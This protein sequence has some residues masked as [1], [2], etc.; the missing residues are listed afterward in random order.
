MIMQE[1]AKT[2]IDRCNLAEKLNIIDDAQELYNIRKLR[3][4]IAHEY[5]ISD[6]SKI[7]KDVLEYTEVLLKTAKK[8]QSYIDK[9]L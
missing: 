2:F 6:I 3:N 8:V 5:C 7:F 4:D 1:D 9:T